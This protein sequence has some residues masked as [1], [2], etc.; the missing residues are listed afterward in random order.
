[1]ND[2]TV[3]DDV[4]GDPT[5]GQYSG[6]T[7][8]MYPLSCHIVFFGGGNEFLGGRRNKLKGQLSAT[9]FIMCLVKW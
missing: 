9:D 4:T 3:I 6:K 2:V 8:G 5:H 7:A 1:M